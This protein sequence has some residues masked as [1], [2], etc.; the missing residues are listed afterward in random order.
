MQRERVTF[1]LHDDAVMPFGDLGKSASQI[2]VERGSPRSLEVALRDGAEFSAMP[3]DRRKPQRRKDAVKVSD[4]P[5]AHKRKRTGSA[6][7]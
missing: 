1:V 7:P 4:R 2:F 6:V 3:A 5:P